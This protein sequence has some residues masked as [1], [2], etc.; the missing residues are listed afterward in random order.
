MNSLRARRSPL[1][2]AAALAGLCA[3]AAFGSAPKQISMTP[4][5]GPNRPAAVPEGYV[6][7]PFGY[8]HP[9]CVRTLGASEKLL[10]DGRVRHA[11]GTTDVSAAVCAYAHFT[12]N[13]M[14]AKN[15]A[16]V[17]GAPAGRQK[18]LA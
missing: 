17:S 18:R 1:V 9:S 10:A 14:L 6:I 11:D 3:S 13:G 5:A 2:Y 12:A 7:T 15:G 8:F 16:R 4:A